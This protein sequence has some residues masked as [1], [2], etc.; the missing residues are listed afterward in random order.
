[1][2]LRKSSTTER[3]ILSSRRPRMQ[4]PACGTLPMGNELVRSMVIMEPFGA[5][6]STG[7]RIS[8]SP[9]VVT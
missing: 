6:I 2:P 3:V 7:R 4:I 8:S 9:A 5:S 1:M